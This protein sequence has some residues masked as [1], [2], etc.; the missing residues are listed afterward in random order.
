MTVPAGTQ[1][2]TPRTEFAE[3]IVF[4]TEDDLVIRQPELTACVTSTPDG[5]YADHWNDLQL[6]DAELLWTLLCANFDRALDAKYA[7]H[8]GLL[9]STFV[10]PLGELTAAEFESG[11]KQV[12]TL[13]ATYGTTYTS[14]DMVFGAETGGAE[15]EEEDPGAED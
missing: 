15:V 6:E 7:I 13:R 8:R 12:Y 4:I 11:L 1:V 9:W 2:G 10:H 5:L 3:S 14:T